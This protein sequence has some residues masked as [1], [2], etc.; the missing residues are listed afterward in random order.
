MPVIIVDIDGT[1]INGSSGIQKTIDYVNS[2]KATHDIYIV[3][4]RLKSEEDATRAALQKHGIT[5]NRLYLNPTSSAQTLYH[6][7]V[8]AQKILEHEHVV[9][10]IDNNSNMRDMYEELGIKA[11]N[12]SDIRSQKLQGL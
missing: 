7:K 10:A 3:T 8:I 9:L 11:L 2:K 1:L 4:G 12:P 6:K 5:Y